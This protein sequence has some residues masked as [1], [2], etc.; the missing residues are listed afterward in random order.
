MAIQWGLGLCGALSVLTTT[1]IVISLIGPTI[2]FFEI[3]PIDEL[4]KIYGPDSPQDLK[5]SDVRAGFPADPVNRFM[6]GADSGTFD[7]FTEA[8]NGDEGVTRK[9]YNNVGEDDN[10]T[11]KGVAGAPGGMGYAGFSFYRENEGKLKALE[12]DGGKGCVSPSAET[13][14]DDSY[15]PL[16]R[17]LFI[18]PS[19]KGLKEPQVK[20]FVRYYLDN[21]NGIA[22]A[23][24]YIPLTEGQLA[25]SEAA[26]EKIGL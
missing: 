16:S 26:A 13:A 3:V 20:A 14:Q 1:A 25:K 4:A 5:W 11:V 2:G 22:E 12:V 9:D 21:V 23:V 8:I 10:A 24:G 15:T 17:P 6:P 18:Y 7:Y 19:D